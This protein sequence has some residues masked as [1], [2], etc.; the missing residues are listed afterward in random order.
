MPLFGFGFE[1]LLSS[2]AN[3]GTL[4]AGTGSHALNATVSG[5]SR[6]TITHLEDSGL[7]TGT[8]TWSF[9]W[10]RLQMAQL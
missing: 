8:K 1:A 9:T 7:V 3:A 2:G 4:T 10:W 6:K 5:N